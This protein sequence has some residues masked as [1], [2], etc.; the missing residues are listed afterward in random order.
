[1][2]IRK[3]IRRIISLTAFALFFGGCGGIEP[4]KRDYPLSLAWDYQ[5]GSYTLIYGMAELSE[6]TEQ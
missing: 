5:E 4:E 1:M 3:S 6:M 2:K